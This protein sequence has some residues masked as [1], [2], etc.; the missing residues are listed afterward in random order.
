MDRALRAEI[1]EKISKTIDSFYKDAVDGDLSTAELLKALIC[2]Q[3]NIAR[4]GDRTEALELRLDFCK[5][6]D[7]FYL[8]GL[9]P[10]DFRSN[11]DFRI[12]ERRAA[13]WKSNS[14]NRKKEMPF[15]CEKT[16]VTDLGVIEVETESDHPVFHTR[17]VLL[18]VGYKCFYTEMITHLTYDCQILRGGEAKKRPIFQISVNKCNSKNFFCVQDDSQLKAWIQVKKALQETYVPTLPLFQR[19]CAQEA[20][21]AWDDDELET[22]F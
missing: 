3:D 22:R 19:I 7:K 6:L 20:I 13:V 4:F 21:D 18:P 10:D 14:S 17:F 11:A 15:S 8:D 1:F 12:V 2:T 9:F 16:T 5:K